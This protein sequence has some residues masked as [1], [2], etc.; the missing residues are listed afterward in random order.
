MLTAAK[1]SGVRTP[2]HSSKRAASHAGTPWDTVKPSPC[3]WPLTAKLW[4]LQSEE[5]RGLGSKAGQWAGCPKWSGASR[6]AHCARRGGQGQARDRPP[7]SPPGWP[8]LDRAHEGILLTRAPGYVDCWASSRA[9]R[10]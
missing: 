9:H 4:L 5:A 1:D 8:V 10:P 3:F 6:W 7:L 2:S